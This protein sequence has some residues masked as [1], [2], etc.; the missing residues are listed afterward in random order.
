MSG[1]CKDCEHWERILVYAGEWG[2]CKISHGYGETPSDPEKMMHA[3]DNEDYH[4]VL[5]TRP[6]FGCNQFK[7]KEQA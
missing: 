6:E 4:A 5:V 2:Q 3:R 1:L 7:F